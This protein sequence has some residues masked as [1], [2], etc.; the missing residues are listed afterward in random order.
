MQ[1]P[2]SQHLLDFLFVQ[3]GAKKGYKH[4]FFGGF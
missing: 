3:I 4:P 2:V 1:N